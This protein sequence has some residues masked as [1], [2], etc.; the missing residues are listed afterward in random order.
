MNRRAAGLCSSRVGGSSGD[1]TS[2]G[3]G[4]RSTEMKAKDT[5]QPAGP[6]SEPAL[7]LNQQCKLRQLAKTLCALIIMV[8]TPLSELIQQNVERHAFK[9]LIVCTT[10]GR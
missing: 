7:P 2:A 3:L 9:H 10:S 1:G 8:F 6:C 5:G 4:P